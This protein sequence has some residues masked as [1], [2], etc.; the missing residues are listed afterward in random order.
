MSDLM[1]QKLEI[2]CPKCGR[3]MRPE[4]DA[5][6]MGRSVRC[7]GGHSVKLKDEGGGIAKADRAMSDL[8]RALKRFGK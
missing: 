4:L 1:K 3:T 2:K 8:E 5:V 6:K 7:A